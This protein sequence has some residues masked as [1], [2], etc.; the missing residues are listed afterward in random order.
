MVSNRMNSNTKSAKKA[1]E[2][3]E[4]E[5]ARQ[6]ELNII[7]EQ[8]QNDPDLQFDNPYIYTYE[9]KLMMLDKFEEDLI[10]NDRAKKENRR[11]I[12]TICRM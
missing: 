6:I 2:D 3:R 12:Q 1:D 5:I 7:K 9:K 8:L 11:G 10:K 4:G